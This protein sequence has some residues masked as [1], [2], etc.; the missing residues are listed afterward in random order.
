MR[1][2]LE[3]FASE[4]LGQDYR[5]RG[6]GKR[7][8]D[9]RTRC[10]RFERCDGVPLHSAVIAGRGYLSAHCIEGWRLDYCFRRRPERSA[11]KDRLKGRD[12]GRVP[13]DDQR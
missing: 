9:K 7:A 12:L 8:A 13:T 10:Q 2:Q 11:V 4:Q 6:I 5:D 1:G 3:R